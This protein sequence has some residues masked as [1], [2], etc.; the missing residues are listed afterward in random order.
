[1]KDGDKLRA[2]RIRNILRPPK[3]K[4]K[5]KKKERE[6][7]ETLTKTR[8]ILIN[9]LIKA[10]VVGIFGE[11]LRSGSYG[12][13]DWQSSEKLKFLVFKRAFILNMFGMERLVNFNL[14]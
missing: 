11:N 12:R 4:K 6:K 7:K 10:K 3:K 1:M 13:I 2:L 9:Q 8:D 14:I 5:K